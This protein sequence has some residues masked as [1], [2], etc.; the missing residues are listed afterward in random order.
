MHGYFPCMDAFTDNLGICMQNFRKIAKDLNQKT[1]KILQSNTI[2]GRLK[3]KNRYWK[4]ELQAEISQGASPI[5][6]DSVCKIS[7]M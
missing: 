6:N 3:A 7:P 5:T 1:S 4:T 2:F